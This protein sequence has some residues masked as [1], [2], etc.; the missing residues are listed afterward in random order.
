MFET[1]LFVREIERYLNG[2]VKQMDQ[3]RMGQL[4]GGG[5][6]ETERIYERPAEKETLL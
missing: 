4:R 2:M 1:H 3:H 6:K 5:Q